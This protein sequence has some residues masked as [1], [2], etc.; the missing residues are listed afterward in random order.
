MDLTDPVVPISNAI[1]RTVWPA[2]GEQPLA[3]LPACALRSRTVMPDGDSCVENGKRLLTRDPPASREVRAELYVQLYAVSPAPPARRG[4]R[5][6][7][8][9]L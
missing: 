4:P 2:L 3:L 6:P 8:I 1:D 7:E 9:S 5:A